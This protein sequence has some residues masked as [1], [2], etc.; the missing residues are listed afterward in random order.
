[1]QSQPPFT[2]KKYLLN[3]VIFVRHHMTTEITEPYKLWFYSSCGIEKYICPLS[4]QL[5]AK[6]DK[7]RG[8]K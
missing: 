2:L 1:M 5:W 6:C 3:V 7:P 8:R 4:K